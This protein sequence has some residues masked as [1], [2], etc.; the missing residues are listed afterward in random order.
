MS[1]IFHGWRR[2]A[3]CVTLLLA[4]TMLTGWLRSHLV[5]DHLIFPLF[6]ASHQIH[7]CNGNFLWVVQHSSDIDSIV[8]RR[9]LRWR[10]FKANPE[11]SLNMLLFSRYSMGFSPSAEKTVSV[12]ELGFWYMLP[13]IPLTLF[14]AYLMREPRKPNS[15]PTQI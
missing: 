4:L 11:Y 8:N 5:T 15:G 13:L 1:D 10:T 12:K 2:K 14:S 6:G 7:S 3:G 9:P